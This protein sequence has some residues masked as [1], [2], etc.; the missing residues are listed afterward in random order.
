MR[1]SQSGSSRIR[2][3]LVGV[4]LLGLA[5]WQIMAAQQGLEITTLRST[6]PPLTIIAPAGVA[7]GERPLVLIA[8]GFAGSATVMRGFAFTLAHAGYATL[9]WDFDGH[10]A[11]PLVLGSQ[12]L[13]ADADVALGVARERG[14][15][16]PGKVAILGHSMGSGVALQFGQTH[17]DTAATIAISPVDQTVT[18]ELPHNLLLMAGALEPQF[19]STAE[20]ILA[21]AGG[22]GGDI[23]TGT[24]RQYNVIANVEHMSILFAPAAQRQAVAWL[25][26]VFGRQ[27]GA[28]DYTDVRVLWYALAMIGA[29]FIAAALAARLWDLVYEIDDVAERTLQQRLAALLGGV[30]AASALLWLAGEAGYNVRTLFGLSVGG[31]LVIW[32]ALAGLVALALLRAPSALPS[33]RA[34]IGGLLVF[35]VLW[36]GVGLLA[37]VVW[38]PWLL[39]WPRL[40]LWPLAVVC[41]L[42]WYIAVAQLAG[43]SGLAVQLGRWLAHSLIVVGGL[44]LAMQLTPGIG[45]LMLILPALPVLFLVHAIASAPHRGW[46]PFAIS[47]ALFTSWMLLAI[48]PLA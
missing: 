31:Y 9:S 24:A 39:I 48:F 18:Q 42:P 10:G 12:P 30:L 5:L 40:R 20:S 21:Q 13:L 38:Y 45:F 36:L 2:F 11:N 8:H 25:D 34:V 44:F 1:R 26:S 33:A 4:F 41:L 15:V 47:G 37:D 19:Q 32:F 46:W 14:L 29:L 7:A 6:T 35:A 17:P 3:L 16:T 43:G 23:R 28:T 27:P 22:A